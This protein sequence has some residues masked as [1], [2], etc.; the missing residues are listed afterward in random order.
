ME[1]ISRKLKDL[2]SCNQINNKHMDVKTGRSEKLDRVCYECEN[3]VL[4]KIY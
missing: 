2:Q 1:G 3:A 4:R